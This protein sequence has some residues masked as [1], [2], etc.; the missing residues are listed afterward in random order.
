MNYYVLYEFLSRGVNAIIGD[1]MFRP[2]V[3]IT[4]VAWAA[5]CI[6][7]GAGLIYI[8]IYDVGIVKFCQMV[9]NL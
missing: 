4:K 3:P 6:L 5:T 7:T 2:L 1:Y 9:L 8:N